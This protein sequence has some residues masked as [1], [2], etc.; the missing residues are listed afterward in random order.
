MTLPGLKIL[1]D[2]ITVRLDDRTL[3][4]AFDQHPVDHPADVVGADDP[5]HSDLPG[6]DVDRQVDDLGNVSI[7]E[8]GLAD[9]G[10]GVEH[11]GRRRHETKLAPGGPVSFKPLLRRFLGRTLNG[12]AP[13]PGK[14]RRRSG[15]RI[16]GCG[17]VGEDSL[18]L[19][20]SDA[21]RL[22]R[23]LPESS[24]CPLADF[25]SAME[26]ND[27]VDLFVPVEFDVSLAPLGETEREPD[28]LVS[29]GKAP[30]PAEIIGLLRQCGDRAM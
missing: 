6:P 11:L 8:V 21:S 2:C 13:H 29:A 15:P 12:V 24:V 10:L 14:S 3:Q 28:V 4:L 23:H 1:G 17:R 19:I 25:G 26:Q 27:P 18:H 7:R 22:C 30:S 5:V 16:A 9:P 20:E